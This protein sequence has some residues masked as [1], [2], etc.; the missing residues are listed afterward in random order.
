MP[1][2]TR[3][4]CS[5]QAWG[6]KVAYASQFMNLQEASSLGAAL[7]RAEN[8]GLDPGGE[9]D[10]IPIPTTRGSSRVSSSADCSTRTNSAILN[11]CG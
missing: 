7:W 8:D 4:F 1:P 3:R 6:R 5:R 9:C 10:G 2:G 11:E